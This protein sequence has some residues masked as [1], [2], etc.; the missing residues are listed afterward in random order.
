MRFE[1]GANVQVYLGIFFGLVF[2]ME[3]HG[4]A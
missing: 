3:A 1:L 4:V 2:Y